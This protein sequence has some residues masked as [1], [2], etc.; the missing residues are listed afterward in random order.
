M[1]MKNKI[2]ILLLITITPAYSQ[3]VHIKVKSN[4]VL[5]ES[6]IGNGVQWSP[7]P[8][9]DISESDWQRT[10]DRLDFMKINFIRLMVPAEDYCITYPLGGKPEFNWESDKL[11]RLYKL[12]NY[13][14]SR[15]VA[16]LLGDWSDPTRNVKIVDL[17]KRD[18]KFDGIQEYDPRWTYIIG[19]FINHLSVQKKYTCIKYYNLGNEPN[20]DWM[21]VESFETWKRSILNLDQ[22]LSRRHLRNKIK[23]VGPDCAW[24][25][26]WIKKIIA[27]KELVNA[28]DAYEVHKYATDKE[29]EDGTYGKDMDYYR[30]YINEHDSAGKSKPFFMGEVGLVTGK[31]DDDKQPFVFNFQ[32]GVWMTDFIIQSMRAGQ[33]GLIA[34]DLD[35]AMHSFG[36]KS[37]SDDVN[38]YD[39]KVWGF[40]DSFA[41]EK[42]KPEL[43]NLRPWYYTWSLMSKYTPPGSQVLT[44]SETGVKGLR[45]SASKLVQGKNTAFTFSIV[46]EVDEPREIILSV[47]DINKKV[48]LF[49]FNYFEEDM[50]VDEM[51]FPKV[52]RILKDSDPGK[53]IKISMPAKG[54]II[55]TTMR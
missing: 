44:T 16:V 25:D 42:G 2:I 53:G 7:Y 52:K 4:E 29:I 27:D 15:N 50:P 45:C 11:K 18:L 49:Q 40:W 13:C 10:F 51:G 12:L 46:N 23:I 54:I 14:E 36:D 31:T 24:A 17:W 39:W 32:Y 22:E 55:L 9:L 8:V 28:I 5:T 48:N 33:A 38:A 1:P 6:Y 26:D 34:W 3:I 43:A 41:E 47:G 19:E 30:K 37:G 20:G 35:D 21:N